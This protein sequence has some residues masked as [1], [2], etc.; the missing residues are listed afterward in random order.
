MNCIFIPIEY[1]RQRYHKGRLVADNLLQ[2]KACASDLIDHVIFLNLIE[3]H[4]FQ[5]N[6]YVG[7]LSWF[8]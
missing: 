3:V 8:Q 4:H 5:S 1:N 2:R 7:K 6:G